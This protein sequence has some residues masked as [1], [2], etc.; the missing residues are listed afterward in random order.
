KLTMAVQLR[1]MPSPSTPTSGKITRLSTLSWNGR[2]PLHGGSPSVIS[3]SHTSSSPVQSLSSTST[4]LNQSYSST[5]THYHATSF[6]G[7]SLQEKKDLQELNERFRYSLCTATEADGTKGLEYELKILKEKWGKETEN[8]IEIYNEK[9][10][11]LRTQLDSSKTETSDLV[12]KYYDYDRKWADM[13]RELVY[14]RET[15]DK[16]NEKVSKL[17]NKSIDLKYKLEMVEKMSKHHI[18]E[19]ERYKFLLSQKREE[20]TLVSKDASVKTSELLKRTTQCERLQ[21]E[22]RL[23]Y[24]VWERNKKEWSVLADIDSAVRNG[25]YWISYVYVRVCKIQDEYEKLIS[26]YKEENES[27]LRLQIESLRTELESYKHEWS[28]AKDERDRLKEECIDL[29]AKYDQLEVKHSKCDGKY[30]ELQIQWERKRDKCR[31]FKSLIEQLRQQ[32]AVLTEES[33]VHLQA[34]TTLENEIQ[35]YRDLL[36]T[37]EKRGIK[38]TVIGTTQSGDGNDSDPQIITVNSLNRRVEKTHRKEVAIEKIDDEGNY[39]ELQNLTGKAITMTGWKLER[40]VNDKK[41]E[42][43]FPIYNLNAGTSM[44]V[45][46]ESQASLKRDKIDLVAKGIT[47][48]DHSFTAETLLV[49]EHGKDVARYTEQLR[50][51]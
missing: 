40:K 48:W 36:S 50:D 26:E 11:S 13:E 23:L 15:N 41:L 14:L 35:E 47:T 5:P 16:A 1:E 20:L 42:F 31:R 7:V 8:I 33:K 46:P 3:V 12:A 45:Y 28:L 49:D 39:I 34:R 32:M 37:I 10:E 25:E 2:L 21:D 17:K 30:A 38:F 44:K 19:K 18:S 6:C 4:I 27:C 22:L 9:L 43:K 24:Q 51:A 29:Q